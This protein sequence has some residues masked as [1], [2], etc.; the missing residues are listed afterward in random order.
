MC[1]AVPYI[2][3]EIY[4]DESALAVSGG[5]EVNIRLDLI[6]AP[7][8]GDTVLVHAGFAIQKLDERESKELADLWE[9]IR[10]AERTAADHA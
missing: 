4:E 9:E 7:V 6:D 2:I 5:V 3:Q 1:L 10:E 8:L